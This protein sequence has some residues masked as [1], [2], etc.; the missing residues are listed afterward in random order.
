MKEKITELVD[1]GI[2]NIEL[3]MHEEKKHLIDTR[4]LKEFVLC[5]VDIFDKDHDKNWLIS[6]GLGQVIQSRLYYAGYRSVE[7]GYFVKLSTCTDIPYLSRLLKNQ[8]VAINEK[9]LIRSRIKDQLD[10]Q[11]RI[12]FDDNGEPTGTDFNMTQEEFM[13]KVVADSV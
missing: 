7:I 9:Q 8:D 2:E 12:V 4:T 11:G 13:E 1:L 3:Q 6:I 10:G 5:H